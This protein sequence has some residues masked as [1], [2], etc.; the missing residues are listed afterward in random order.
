MYIDKSSIKPL[1]KHVWLATP[2]PHSEMLEYVKEA[3]CQCIKQIH[4]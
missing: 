2:T 4:K 3:Y 1:E